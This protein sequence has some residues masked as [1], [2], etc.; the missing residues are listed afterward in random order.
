LTG[1]FIN[2][3][4]WNIYFKLAIFGF[5]ATRF[6]HW[7]THELLRFVPLRFVPLRFGPLR[8]VPL[9]FGPPPLGLRFDKIGD[10][11]NFETGDILF[12]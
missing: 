4:A 9:R 2:I 8:F 10:D 5:V 6:E 12:T 1:F 3:A 7:V 11:L